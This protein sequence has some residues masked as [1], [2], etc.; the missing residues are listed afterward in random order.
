MKKIE[1]KNGATLLK[2]NYDTITVPCDKTVYELSVIVDDNETLTN[3]SIDIQ[4]NGFI[5][6]SKIG[7][8]IY[9]TVNENNSINDRTGFLKFTH[10]MDK[11]VTYVLN[12]IQEAKVYSIETTY[13]SQHN[14]IE[15]LLNTLTDQ[16]LPNFEEYLIAVECENGN[17]DFVIKKIEEY[18]DS[19][20]QHKIPFDNGIQIKK[21]NNRMLSI[22]NYGKISKLE[23]VTYKVTL[24]HKNDRKQIQQIIIR[25]QNNNTG[26]GFG[27]D[28]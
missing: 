7:N 3:Y 12:F 14:N 19:E 16:T 23:N 20:M 27:F 6:Y 13:E 21:Q 10:S 26:N 5:V 11:N 17:R 8:N 15:L 25:Y 2:Q 4:S 1:L 22:K 18:S 9:V 24:C 28:D